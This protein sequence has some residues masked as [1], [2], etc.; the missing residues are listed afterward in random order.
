MFPENAPRPIP[1]TSPTAPHMSCGGSFFPCTFAKRAPGPVFDLS[2]N[3][4]PTATMAPVFLKGMTRQPAYEG[5][6]A[7]WDRQLRL[8]FDLRH[9]TRCAASVPCWW[10]CSISRF[11]MRSRTSPRSPICNFASTCSLPCHRLRHPAGCLRLLRG[12]LVYDLGL[13]SGD[14]L[15]APSLWE[16]CRLVLVIAFALTTPSGGWQFAFPMAAMLVIYVFS[17]DQGMVSTVLRSSAL[18]R[19]GLWSYSIYM[20]HSFVFQVMKMGAS[21]I[22]QKAKLDL[23][24]W[25]HDEKLMLLG[26]PGQALLP[27]L[28][29]SVVL[30]VPIAALTYRWI[31]KPAM[32][33]ARR[34][35]STTRGAT[36]GTPWLRAG[37]ARG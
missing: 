4:G 36:S 21:F 29:L 26:T 19:L 8:R 14:R 34:G 18:Q 15:E 2:L 25:H 6:V 12:G 27:A 28:M 30:V 7:C 31:E 20:I 35:L 3:A 10:S 22:G 13:R 24:G 16:A 17:F 11:T 9:W 1:T 33:A 37:S 32:D 23:V 5:D